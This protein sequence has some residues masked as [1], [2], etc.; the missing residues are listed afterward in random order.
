M[1]ILLTRETQTFIF[2]FIQAIKKQIIKKK[3]IWNGDYGADEKLKQAVRYPK[4]Q[5][6]LV[7]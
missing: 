1:F 4:S 7:I 2:I 5:N 3:K 6:Y